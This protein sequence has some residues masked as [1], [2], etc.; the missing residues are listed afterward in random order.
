MGRGTRT[1]T[2]AENAPHC[3]SLTWVAV[4]VR[5]QVP[6]L[7]R[8]VQAWLPAV[9]QPLP[10]VA[11]AVEAVHL[12]TT[13]TTHTA[14]HVIRHSCHTATI[15]HFNVVLHKLQGNVNSQ[16]YWARGRDE[17]T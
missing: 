14:R 15:W 8:A 1:S 10:A 13:A 2:D 17:L 11:V 12:Y 5:V 4:L 7:H 6:S 16:S 9:V 3:T